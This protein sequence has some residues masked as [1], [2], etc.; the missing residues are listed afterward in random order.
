MFPS[1][2][3]I[4]LFTTSKIVGIIT[5]TIA[6]INISHGINEV[7]AL[8]IVKNSNNANTATSFLL[9]TML[10]NILYLLNSFN[11]FFFISPFLF[12]IVLFIQGRI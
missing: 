12:S 8:I 2:L 5:D 10:L 9:L 1:F 7:T 4:I 11:G 6:T 3:V